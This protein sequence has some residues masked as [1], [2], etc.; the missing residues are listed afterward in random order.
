MSIEESLKKLGKVTAGKSE[1]EYISTMGK[2][3][4]AHACA[5]LSR[6]A[7]F[8]LNL[9]SLKEET[10]EGICKIGQLHHRSVFLPSKWWEKDHG[11]LLGYYQNQ[12]VALICEEGGYF[13][14]LPD[15]KKIR[16]SE[17]IEAEIKPEAYMLYPALPE[18]MGTMKALLY[19]LFERKSKD[20]I[21]LAITGILAG[22]T[23][24]FIPFAN[25]ILFDKVI[26]HFNLG[27]LGQ[28]LLGLL[29]AV[30]GSSLFMIAR[31]FIS[32]RLNAKISHQLQMSLWDRILK[33][34][35]SFFRMIPRGDL[36]QRTMV[37]NQIRRNFGPNTMIA[38]FDSLFASIYLV[39]MLY[40]NW[41]LAILGI[42]ILLLTSFAAFLLAS[43]KIKWDKELLASDANINSFLIG[44]IQGIEKLR[45]AAAENFFFSSWAT[46][47]SENQTI[48][49]K[50]RFIDASA[51]TINRV[52]SLFFPF[53]I[54][55]IVI[56]DRFTDPLAMTLG[57]YLAFTAAAA[58]FFQSVL[59][60]L[61]LGIA[62]VSLIP[63]WQ[64]VLPLLTHSLEIKREQLPP[65]TLEGKI[66]LR[67]VYFRYQMNAPHVLKDLS[68]EIN[69]G[70]FIAIV[71]PSGCGK[72]TICRLLVGFES[73]QR[74]TI[75]YDDR[76][77]KE[78]LLHEL[79]EQMSFVMQQKAIFSGTFYENIAC[80]NPYSFEEIEAAAKM[81]TL[82]RDMHRF[83]SG[84]Q[85]LLPSGG[86]I[87]SAGERQKLLL[88]RAL[89]RKPKILI[90]DEGLNSLQSCMQREILKTLRDLKITRILAT[91]QLN[92]L[93]VVDRIYLLEG[94]QFYAQGTFEELMKQEPRFRELI[95]K[96]TI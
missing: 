41:K 79:R 2:T 73:P 74:G 78:L 46:K 38:L 81:T 6:S 58:P 75:Q 70:D 66:S 18:E 14:V 95:E 84:W 90:L 69:P 28:V 56:W 88:T 67:N 96:Q 7:G 36:I 30:L 35:V 24:L 92:I 71:G 16:V 4:L 87:L 57:D 60:F 42:G 54:Y 85:T 23:A 47:Y 17:K 13:C 40:Y 80:G 62:L 65:G 37:F 26:P 68:L 21:Y 22:L 77:L 49:L 12:P 61:N 33:L 82:D 44:I 20:Y 34:P 72:S 55:G 50:S 11:P 15:E 1:A 51:Q 19:V 32:L 86:S 45:I 31:S 91:H 27:M 76:N 83:P 10:L 29:S 48:S 39:I 64:R 8:Q 53:L 3:P 93:T 43:L 5:I 9:R 25:K 63:F 59:G 89:I 52:I 94:G